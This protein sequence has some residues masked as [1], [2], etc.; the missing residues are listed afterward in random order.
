MFEICT[1]CILIPTARN[2]CIYHYIYRKAYDKYWKVDQ[3]KFK[4]YEH[5]DLSIKLIK[6]HTRSWK[7]PVCHH[8][9]IAINYTNFCVVI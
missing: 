5:H 1:Q 9:I 2:I 8:S 4:S 7:V 3:K 6:K